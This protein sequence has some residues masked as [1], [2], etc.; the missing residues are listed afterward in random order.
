MRLSSVLLL[1]I[2]A[3]SVLADETPKKPRI[4]SG[5]EML[6]MRATSHR[7]GPQFTLD[8]TE[9]I[10]RYAEPVT[11]TIHGTVETDTGYMP[12]R[13]LKIDCTA[14]CKSA[15]HY[16]EDLGPDL[17]IGLLLF[18]DLD[19]QF[20]TLSEGPTTL[21]LRIYSYADQGIDKVLEVGTDV[22]PCF[23]LGDGL[24]QFEVA[25]HYKNEGE[26]AARLHFEVW[27]WNGD[28]YVRTVGKLGGQ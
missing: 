17:P 27:T 19:D 9:R 15:V 1:T 5:P 11:S 13:T 8:V 14:N 7:L 26:D 4:V 2:L 3:S 10:E 6:L 20:I 24:K 28:A 18:P 22:F 25:L 23:N 12:W 16:E 21:V